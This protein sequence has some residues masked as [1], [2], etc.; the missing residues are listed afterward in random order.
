[1]SR[2]EVHVPTGFKQTEIGPLPEN[3]DVVSLGDLFEVQQGKAMSPQTRVGLFPTPFLR[4]SNV[5]WGRVDLNEVDSMDF[6]PEERDFYSLRTGD[7]LVCEGGE[8][9]RSAIWEGGIARC[10]F[11]NH[12]HRLRPTSG[13]AFPEFYMYW[14]QAAILLL[15]LYR[16]A[17]NKTTIPNL[18]KGRLKQ[19]PVPKPPFTEQE[20]IARMLQTSQR[21]IRAIEEKASASED[22]F[23][24]MLHESMT[25]ALIP[26]LAKLVTK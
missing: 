22:L 26:S 9:G 20:S 16:G 4:T 15:G 7:L 1:M 6:N 10:C 18:S 24:S 11:Q 25:G 23:R 2:A 21:H 14:M 19:L 12:I 5:L 17:G 3:W 13:E 8:V